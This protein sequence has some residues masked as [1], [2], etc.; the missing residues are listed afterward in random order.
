MKTKLLE[1][2]YTGFI[3]AIGKLLAKVF[4]KKV[5]FA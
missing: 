2:V 4:C 1:A 3:K 5:I